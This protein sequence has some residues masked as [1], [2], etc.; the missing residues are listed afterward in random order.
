M[1]LITKLLTSLR[2]KHMDQ[3]EWDK[4]ESKMADNPVYSREIFQQIKQVKIFI[5]EI[6]IL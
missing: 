4:N 3:S 2:L 5:K 1:W 6:Y